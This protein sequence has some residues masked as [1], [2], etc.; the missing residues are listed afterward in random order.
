MSQQYP[1]KS[2][3]FKLVKRFFAGASAGTFLA[4]I[5]WSYSIFTHSN[6]SIVQGIIGVAVSSITAGL[7]ASFT[8]VDKLMNS[9]PWI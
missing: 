3:S 4:L 8:S 2:A 5:Y 9:L 6:P 7:I 1:E